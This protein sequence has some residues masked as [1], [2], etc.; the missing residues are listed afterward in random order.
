MS[1]FVKK[2]IIKSKN[3]IYDIANY[4]LKD[5]KFCNHNEFICEHI[6]NLSGYKT[7]K[8]KLNN[9]ETFCKLYGHADLFRPADY[10]Q[11]AGGC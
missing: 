11:M 4:C 9:G 2:Q 6:L 8:F 3:N 1:K 10:R 7:N 5:P